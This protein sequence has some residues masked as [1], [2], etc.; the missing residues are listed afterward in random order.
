MTHRIVNLAVALTVASV[1]LASPV[2]ASPPPLTGESTGTAASAQSCRTTT[3][4][5]G[6]TLRRDILNALRPR[7][8][9]MAGQPVEFVVERIRVS[10][11]WA[12]VVANPRAP[13]GQGNQYEPVDALLQRTHGVWRL[14]MIACGEED[15]APAAQQYRQSHPSVPAGLLF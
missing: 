6:T 9:E 15:C 14:Q 2:V 4:R 11:D 12:R 13:G 7:I 5:A 8:E 3:P 1:S 10:C